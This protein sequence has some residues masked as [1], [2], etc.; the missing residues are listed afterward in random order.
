[1]LAIT[2][3]NGRLFDYIFGFAHRN[4]LLD[5]FAVFLAQYLPY[6]LVLALLV[7][8]FSRRPARV[9]WYVFVHLALAAILSRGILTE[10]I[11]FA[12]PHLRPF[13]AL[14]FVPL[15]PEAGNSFPSGH[16]AFLFALAGALFYLDRRWGWAFL[17]LASVNGLARVFTGVHW[18]L[19]ILGGTAV[20][21]ISAALV[22]L[23]LRRYSPAP[24]PGS[25]PVR[26]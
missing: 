26:L 10:I 3:W 1:M 9:R 20:G 17:V 7:F 12:Y 6:F 21:L 23:L 8:I 5:S 14:G 19:D 4:P 24:I 13:D 16:A 2:T 25:E 22:H 18:P 15:L 11:R